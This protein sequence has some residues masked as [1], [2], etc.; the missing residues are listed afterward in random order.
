MYTIIHEAKFMSPCVMNASLPTT[1]DNKIKNGVHIGNWSDSCIN[2][3]TPSC[4]PVILLQLQSERM[5]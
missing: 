1:L 4:I 2:I 5:Q 3:I